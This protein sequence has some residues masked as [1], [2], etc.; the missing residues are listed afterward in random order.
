[1]TYITGKVPLPKCNVLR[2]R[3]SKNSYVVRYQLM[4]G[5]K[6]NK[7]Q[8]NVY[9]GYMRGNVTILAI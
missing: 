1:M 4:T 5:K 8:K 6:T 2:S 9:W 3:T 7:F